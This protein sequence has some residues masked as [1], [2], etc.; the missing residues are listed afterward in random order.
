MWLYDLLWFGA[1][2]DLLFLLFPLNIAYLTLAVLNFH[3]LG[4]VRALAASLN[5]STSLTFVLMWFMIK[6]S[7]R[8]PLCW[9]CNFTEYKHFDLLTPYTLYIV[10]VLKAVLSPEPSVRARPRLVVHEQPRCQSLRGQPRCMGGGCML[11]GVGL[12]LPWQ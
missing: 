10:S 1:V 8:L 9:H 4:F 5:Y 2:F 7:K 3:P 6:A 11:G 12:S